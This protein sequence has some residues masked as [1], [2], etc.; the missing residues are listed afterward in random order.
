MSETDRKETERKRPVP[1]LPLVILTIL[2]ML[3]GGYV[4]SYCRLGPRHVVH[5]V[6]GP[7]QVPVVAGVVRL[8]PHKWQVTA[9]RPAAYIESLCTGVQVHLGDF[10]TYGDPNPVEP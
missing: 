7:G 8:Y 6:S 2:A 9:F 4:L 1:L 5:G 3:L 10:A